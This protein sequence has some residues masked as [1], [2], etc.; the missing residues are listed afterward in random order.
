ME[1]KEK[2]RILAGAAKYDVSCSSSGSNRSS[3]KGTLG[4]VSSSGICHSYTPD[5]KCI[6]LL[7]ILFTNYCIYDCSYCINRRSNNIERASF[8]VREVIDLTINFYRRNYIE[9]LFLSSSIIK[10]P[11]YT[12][13]LLFNVVSELRNKYNFRGYIHLKAIP[14]ADDELIKKAG[15]L[16][17]RMSVNL[18]L[19]SSSSLKLLAPEK[20]KKS[21]LKP[22]NDIKNNIII[23]KE[24]RKKYK[25]SPIF[26]PG[27]QSTQLIIGATNESDLKILNLSENLYN[28]FNLKRVYY[29]AYIP[30]NNDKNLPEIKQPPTLREHRLYQ[31][32]WL[33]RFYGFKANEILNTNN[34]NLDINFDPKTSYALNNID[35]FPVEINLAPFNTLI[36]VPGIGLKG[37][38]K[39]VSARKL[40]SLD[41]YDLKKMGIVIKRAQFFITCNGKYY[42]CV[43]FDDE[44]IRKAL[45]PKFDLNILDN[46][47]EQ[48]SFFTNK[49]E[50]NNIFSTTLPKNKVLLLNDYNSSTNGDF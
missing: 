39:I 1:L 38:K 35:K 22:M 16:V 25:N 7:K 49:N 15:L 44:K 47:I 41:F 46:D 32:D 12:M 21:I 31:S 34:P 33:L 2:L 43:S 24:E 18:E 19:P 23:N 30:V 36:R 20:D 45:T 29:S 10:N 8:T 14:G 9:G 50:I 4:S 26:V 3:K 17:D 13:E 40:N 5:G 28:K 42:G 11:N 6:S 27:G 37:A 48:L